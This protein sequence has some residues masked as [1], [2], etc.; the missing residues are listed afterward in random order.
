MICSPRVTSESS[1]TAGVFASNLIGR[2][3]IHLFERLFSRVP[4]VSRI[5]N[6]VSTVAG[7]RRAYITAQTYAEHRRA[8]G[9]AIIDDP[10]DQLRRT[11]KIIRPRGLETSGS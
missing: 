4:L 9:H 7:G 1:A 5:Y 11:T 8:F 6:A 2:Q 3:V 10:I